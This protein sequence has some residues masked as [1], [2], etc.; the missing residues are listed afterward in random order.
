MYI[1]LCVELYQTKVIQTNTADQGANAYNNNQKVVFKNYAPFTDCI[2]KRNNTQVDNANDI[3][4]V[5]SMYN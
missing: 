4:I 5:I 3:D 1:Y 2:S